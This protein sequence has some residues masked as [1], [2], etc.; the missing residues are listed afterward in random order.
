MENFK[1]A[2][3]NIIGFIQPD[4]NITDVFNPQF[5]NFIFPSNFVILNQNISVDIS[6]NNDSFLIELTLTL[7]E[8]FEFSDCS[9]LYHSFSVFNE[10]D[11]LI[12]VK[13]SNF[14]FF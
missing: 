1:T 8:Y 6:P 2:K 14:T 12:N 7:P 13:K 5:F 9:S 4:F 10:V 11:N 3:I